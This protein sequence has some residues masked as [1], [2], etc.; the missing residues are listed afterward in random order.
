MKKI[1]FGSLLAGI[2]TV[3]GLVMIG[4]ASAPKTTSANAQAQT[5]KAD[6]YFD[7][8][9]LKKA[10]PLYMDVANLED[11]PVAL[12]AWTQFR[13]GRI[14]DI[15]GD[16]AK[17]TEWYTKA[18]TLGEKT[19]Q[20]NLGN[21]YYNQKDYDKALEWYIKSAVQGVGQA[22]WNVAAYYYQ[23]LGVQEDNDKFAEWAVKA[24]ELGNED[25]AK[26]LRQMGIIK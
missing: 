17:S 21:Y 12:K 22:A 14:Y 26:V 16:V 4:C 8:K 20:L 10:L 1:G 19:A 24:Y 7:N 5:V 11:I 15:Q 2:V 9:D 18:A 25:A 3:A 6:S 23:G 13:V